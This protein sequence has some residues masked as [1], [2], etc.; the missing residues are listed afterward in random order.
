L[1]SGIVISVSILS[2]CGC[3]Y[4]IGL[5]GAEKRQIKNLIV[6]KLHK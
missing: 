2:C 1:R 3:I 5:N 6:S 4:R